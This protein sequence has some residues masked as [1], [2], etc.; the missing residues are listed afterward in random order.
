MEELI[1]EGV[2]VCV[3]AGNYYQKIDVSGG[4]DYNNYYNSFVYYNR[5][6]SPM[7]AE[8]IIVGNIGNAINTGKEVKN[9]SSE[10]GP[11]VDIYAPGTN[12][13]STCSTSNEFG[14]YVT[15]YPNN[16]SF[17]IMNIS[18]TSMASPQVAGVSALLLQVHPHATPAQIRQLIKDSSVA[19]MVYSTGLDNDYTNGSSIKGSVNRTLLSKFNTGT[20][21]TTSGPISFNNTGVR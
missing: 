15:T 10:S 21:V 13:M 2:V 8:A 18:G 16:T 9:S 12:I 17:K 11:R 4:L 7:A 20:S 5:G 3:A 14:G 19:D 6:S 1:A